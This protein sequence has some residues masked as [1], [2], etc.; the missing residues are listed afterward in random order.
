MSTAADQSP[1]SST[2]PLRI[3][4]PSD[5]SLTTIVMPPGAGDDTAD[6]DLSYCLAA[7]PSRKDS[8]MLVEECK[9]CLVFCTYPQS[10]T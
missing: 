2:V 7:M 8:D 1:G 10:L 3:H 5:G 4:A 9:R 6:A